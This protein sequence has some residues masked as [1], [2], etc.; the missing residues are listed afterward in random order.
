[1]ENEIMLVIA[2]ILIYGVGL[3]TG[4]YAASQIDK[5]L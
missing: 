3:A 2:G 5:K 4:L 1:M